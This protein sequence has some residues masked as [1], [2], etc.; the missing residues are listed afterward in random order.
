M[1]VYRRAGEHRAPIAYVHTMADVL[2]SPQYN[3]RGFLQKIDHP[4]AGEASYVGPPWWMGPG[5]WQTGRAP[6]LGEHTVE[7]L[8]DIAGLSAAEMDRLSPAGALA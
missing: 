8:R 1:D 2:A 6:L 4:V 7:V 5:G 3:A